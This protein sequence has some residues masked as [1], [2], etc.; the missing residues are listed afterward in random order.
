M[1]YT[2]ASRCV[3]RRIKNVCAHENLY[4]NVHSRAVLMAKQPSCQLMSE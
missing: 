1:S 3:L 2:L 4:M